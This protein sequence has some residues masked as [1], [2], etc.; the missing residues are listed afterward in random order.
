MIIID[1]IYGEINILSSWKFH[2]FSVIGLWSNIFFLLKET[3]PFKV[4]LRRAKPVLSVV[5]VQ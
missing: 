3:K 4:S 2:V 1:N 5:S